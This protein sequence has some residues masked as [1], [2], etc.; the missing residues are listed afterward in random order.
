M[1]KLAY[2][3]LIGMFM[4]HNRNEKFGDKILFCENF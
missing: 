1:L 2:E 4:I 3:K